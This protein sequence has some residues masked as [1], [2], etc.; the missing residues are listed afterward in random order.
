MIILVDITMFGLYASVTLVDKRDLCSLEAN[1]K[2]F[3]ICGQQGSKV[4]QYVLLLASNS[5]VHQFLVRFKIPLFNFLE[6][7]EFYIGYESLKI[8]RGFG[9]LSNKVIERKEKPPCGYVAAQPDLVH[10]G[11]EQS[12]A[13]SLSLLDSIRSK[14]TPH[15]TPP[16]YITSTICFLLLLLYGLLSLQQGCHYAVV[17]IKVLVLSEL[18]KRNKVKTRLKIKWKFRP[19][20]LI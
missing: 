14:N 9:P 6:E 19:L 17:R 4:L 15:K 5:G 3:I 20:C 8:K 13:L 18:F 2:E 10:R 1:E 12:N 11:G 7:C 16:F